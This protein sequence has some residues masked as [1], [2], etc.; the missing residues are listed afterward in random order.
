MKYLVISCSLKGASRS[1]LMARK[2]FEALEAAGHQAEFLDLRDHPLP[3]CD[4]DQAYNDPQVEFWKGRISGA[5]GILLG[6]PVYNY[7]INAASKNLVELTGRSWEGKAV[8]FLCAAGGQA[9]YM[10]V[11]NLACDLMLDFR[12]LIVP[13]FVYA[14][15]HDFSGEAISNPDITARVE[16]LAG[17]LVKVSRAL[18]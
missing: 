6:L 14:T 8:G 15:K 3:L 17:A 9:S 10:S 2:A 13:R 5:G 12:C 16:E 18:E 7:D 4:G 11:M 1:R